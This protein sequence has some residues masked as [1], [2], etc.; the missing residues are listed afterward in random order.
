MII[1][2][3]YVKSP[4]NY[5]GG[6]YKLLPDLINVFPKDVN[7]FIDLFAGGCNVCINVNANKIIA[8]DIQ[9]N[10][11]DLMKY[12]KSKTADEV[13]NDLD[14]IISK[15]S[16]S[17]TFRNGYEFYN[18]TSSIGVSNY[19]KEKYKKL[20]ADYNLDKGNMALFFTCIIFAFSNQIRFN[21]KGNFNTPVNKRDFNRSMRTNTIEFINKLKEI[22]I[23][24]MNINF[25][26]FNIN[27]LNEN[28]FVYCDP[29]Y[30]ISTASYN[31]YWNSD[32]EAQLLTFLDRLNAK[33][34][35]F[36]LSNVLEHNG[37]KNTQ[38]INWCKKY[39]VHY[40]DKNYNNCSYNLIT[41]GKT[42][43]VIITNY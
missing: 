5:T 16:L 14:Y 17:D 21:L 9:G 34:I 7:T 24:F 43:E 8:N 11:I 22:N 36:A 33:G 30:L 27:I 13:I 6:K 25:N 20:R 10:L 3:Q 32:K 15:Y 4:L 40:L 29:P 2:K 26:D 1:I 19:N 37:L 38:L 35:K 42:I 18:T 39:K 31:K 28:D 12:F 41:K 23:D